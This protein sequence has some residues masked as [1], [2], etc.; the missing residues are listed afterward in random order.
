[1]NKT[2][3]S[4]LNT[5]KISS[6]NSATCCVIFLTF[7]YI[8]SPPCLDLSL[9]NLIISYAY[10]KLSFIHVNWIQRLQR[11]GKDDLTCRHDVP[12]HHHALNGRLSNYCIL[13]TDPFTHL[14]LPTSQFF[15]PHPRPSP[16]SPT[17][18]S[19]PLYPT[20]LS[21]R[22]SPSLSSPQYSTH[23]S[24]QPFPPSPTACLLE[25]P[26]WAPV[27]IGSV[28][29]FTYICSNHMINILLFKKGSTD[30]SKLCMIK[31][32]C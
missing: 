4:L 11:P 26:R 29:T 7:F 32:F 25:Q 16:P 24:S 6:Y 13:H 19:S 21:L 14:S 22:S 15:P 18:L 1:M 20:L 17:L 2:Q 28:F 9:D 31:G 27:K 3:S 30:I 8:K 5:N 10:A 12:W 23:P